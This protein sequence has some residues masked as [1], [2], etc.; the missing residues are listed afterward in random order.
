MEIW[1]SPTDPTPR[2]V[3]PCCDYVSLAERGA[4]LICPLCDW[5]DDGQG[6]RLVGSGYSLAEARENFA[7]HLSMYREGDADHLPQNPALVELKRQLIEV[8]ESL[9]AAA[10]ASP[11]EREALLRREQELCDR[12]LITPRK[13]IPLP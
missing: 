8:Y 2:E 7:R 1:Y 6:G 12:M 9:A 4:Y 13:K 5:E 11:A 3:C 10:A